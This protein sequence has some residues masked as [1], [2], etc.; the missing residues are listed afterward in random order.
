MA[1]NK[2]SFGCALTATRGVVFPRGEKLQRLVRA[3]AGWERLSKA[4][5]ASLFFANVKDNASPLFEKMR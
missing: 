5:V 3:C 4:G 2:L 1:T